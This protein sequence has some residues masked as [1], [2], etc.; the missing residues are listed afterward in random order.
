M[1][2]QQQCLRVIIHMQPIADILALAVGSGLPSSALTIVKG[3]S[4]SGK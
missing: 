1:R 4:F 3:I 2:Y